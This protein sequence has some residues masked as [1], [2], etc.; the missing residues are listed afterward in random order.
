MSINRMNTGTDYS[1]AYFDG[2]TGLIVDLGDVQSVKIN[3]LKHDIKS[4]PYN[5]VPRYGF[6]PDGYRIEF[7]I[8]RTGPVME[9]LMVTFSRNFNAGNVIKPGY[10]SEAVNNPDGSISRYQY[11]NFVIFVDDHGDISREKPVQLRVTGLAS[12]KKFLA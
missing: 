5:D 4:M 7:V 10:F 12:D 2:S 3:A 9:D 8:V 6:V 1:L 11:T